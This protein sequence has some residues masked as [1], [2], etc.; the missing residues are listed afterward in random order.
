MKNSRCLEEPTNTS[1]FSGGDSAA[2]EAGA[3]RGAGNELAVPPRTSAAC[4][5]KIKVP[6]GWGF[7]VRPSSVH[8]H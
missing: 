8:A 1:V 5:S 3:G 7:L 6:A 2:P 4:E